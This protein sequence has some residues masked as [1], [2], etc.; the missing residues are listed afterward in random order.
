MEDIDMSRPTAELFPEVTA[1]DS[2]PQY[3]SYQS[4]DNYYTSDQAVV[5]PLNTGAYR[6]ADVA[7]QPTEQQQNFR[8]LR[9]EIA[10]MQ[11]EREYWKGQ[12]DAFARQPK[13]AEPAQKDPYQDLDWQEPTDLKRAFDSIRQEN[14]S[15]RSEIKDAL[16][17]VETKSQHT[18]WGS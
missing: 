7:G 2:A 3:N 9:E 17:A 11:A 10:K 8:A 5:D 15:L 14:Q 16:K 18:D 1:Q 4:D 12:A 6:Q 13:Q